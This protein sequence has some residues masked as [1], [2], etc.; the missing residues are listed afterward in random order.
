MQS[1]HNMPDASRAR[2]GPQRVDKV[3]E[4]LTRERT[5][6][7][8]IVEGPPRSKC[9]RGTAVDEPPGSLSADER[10]E[11][12]T[13]KWLTRLLS[14]LMQGL[15]Y[16][17]AGSEGPFCRLEKGHWDWKTCT[18]IIRGKIEREDDLSEFTGSVGVPTTR[19]HAQ[20]TQIQMAQVAGFPDSGPFVCPCTL[21]AHR[22]HFSTSSYAIRS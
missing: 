12:Y 10:D 2:K 11:P 20:I 14:G 1:Q 9:H 15:F 3:G 7:S 4:S 19:G 22:P 8:S 13:M 18:R 6:G 16:F 17:D 21:P 5:G